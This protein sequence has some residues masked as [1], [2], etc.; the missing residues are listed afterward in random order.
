[1]SENKSAKVALDAGAVSKIEAALREGLV[2]AGSTNVVNF[3]GPNDDSTSVALDP[4]T[5]ARFTEALRA[6]L[7]NAAANNV[8]D[9]QAANEATNKVK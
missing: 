3:P 6:G 1:M 4:A 9:N 2:N 5:I 7:V 8:H